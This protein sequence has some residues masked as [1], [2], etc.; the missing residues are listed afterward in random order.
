MCR[1]LKSEWEPSLKLIYD[2]IIDF[3][4]L[5]DALFELNELRLPTEIKVLSAHLNEVEA[6]FAQEEADM[7]V[8]ILPLQRLQIPSFRLKTI[9]L[10]LVAHR[11][12]PLGKERGQTPLSNSDLNR[13]TFIAI[14]TAPGALGLSTEQMQFDSYFFVNDFSTKKQAIIKRLGFGWLPDYMIQSE[15][16]KGTL[17]VIKTE[18]DNTHAVHPRLYHRPDPSNGKTATQL[19]KII[20]RSM[21]Q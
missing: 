7:M 19:L 20:R 10:Q 17:R 16:K 3:N 8:T 6:R 21:Q 12:H 18:I 1:K 9:R 2:G 14:K 11:L 15:I 5:G 13:H 4:F